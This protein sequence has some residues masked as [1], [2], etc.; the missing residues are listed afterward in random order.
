MKKIKYSLQIKNNSIKFEFDRIIS[1]TYKLLPLREQR[2][3]WILPLKNL[4]QEFIGLKR[5]INNEEEFFLLI[6]CKMEGLFS[7]TNQEDMFIY[8][9]NILECLRLLN[10]LKQKCLY[11][12]N[13]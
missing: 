10:N 9:K 7:L 2:K 8:R 11:Q 3:D 12:K 5:L 4:I 6:L 1:H 13:I